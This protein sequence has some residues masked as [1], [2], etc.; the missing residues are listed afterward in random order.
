MQIV[1]HFLALFLLVPML[2]NA[3]SNPFKSLKYDKVVAYEFR[4]DGGRVIEHCL[5]NDKKRISKHV[6]LTTKQI[7]DL[8][9]ILTSN[10]SYGS[11]KALCFDPH[12]GVVYYNKNQIIG[13]I[14]ICLDC[15]YLAA[16]EAMPATRIKM[17][18]VSDNYSYPADGFSKEARRSIDEF[19]KKLGFTKY[20]KPLSSIFDQ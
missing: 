13:S 2:I 17:I 8:E 11:T 4:G 19:C 16:S 6:E 12:F 20:L 7:Q 10:S 9:S 3:Q 1:K 15:N 18:S 5:K 14:D